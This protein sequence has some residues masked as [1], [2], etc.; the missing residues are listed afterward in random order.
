MALQ[1]TGLAR[2][3]R[4]K[5]DVILPDPDPGRSP[6]EVMRFYSGQYPELTTASVHGPKIEKDR[7]VYE[8][9][10]TMGTKG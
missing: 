2:E 8:F 3:F 5:H 4:F 9:K 1:I 6:E 10:T 7:Q